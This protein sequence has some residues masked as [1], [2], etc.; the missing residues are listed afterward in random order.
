MLLKVNTPVITR[1][2][3]LKVDGL[4]VG[5]YRFQLCIF[6]E[7]GNKSRADV[8]SVTVAYRT[9]I[10]PITPVIPLGREQP[11][12]SDIKKKSH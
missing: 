12:G 4:Q 5:T 9:I 10:R 3:V 7:Q 8:V 11:A 2:A 1:D 6:D